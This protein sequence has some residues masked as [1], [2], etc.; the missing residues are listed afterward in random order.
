MSRAA[1][2]DEREALAAVPPF[3]AVYREQRGRVLG[4]VRAIIGPSD[5][6]EDV[7]QLAFIEIHRCLDRFEGRSRLSTWCYRIAVNVALQH[8]RRKRRKRWL[9]LG[10]TGDEAGDLA[11]PVHS[12]RR[13]EDREI[14]QKVY[15][16]AD[17]LSEK[18]RVVW[19]LHELRGMDPHEIA[20]VLEIPM[21]TV[22]SRL[23]AARRDLMQSLADMGIIPGGGRGESM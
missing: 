1:D 11:L 4:A 9:M 3:D 18:K 23:L 2:T 14:L 21:N 5:E 12:T 16:A 19:V 17:G 6:V 7:V 10:I 22:R 20:E 13:L 15:R 8:L